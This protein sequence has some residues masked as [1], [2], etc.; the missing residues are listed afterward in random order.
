MT[1]HSASV[2]VRAASSMR[3]HR[4]PRFCGCSGNAGSPSHSGSVNI[5]SSPN[6][7]INAAYRR[8][9]TEANCSQRPSLVRQIININVSGLCGRPCSSHAEFD[10]NASGQRVQIRSSNHAHVS[11]DKNACARLVS[12]RCPSP[13]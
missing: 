4:S 2:L 12:T 10:L 1:V 6:A 8:G 3:T 9:A 5:Q 11:S 13:L 7:A